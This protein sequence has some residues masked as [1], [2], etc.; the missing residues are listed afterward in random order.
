VVR[1]FNAA[2]KRYTKGDINKE[3]VSKFKNDDVIEILFEYIKLDDD[4]QIKN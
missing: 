1:L 2:I 3:E 4:V